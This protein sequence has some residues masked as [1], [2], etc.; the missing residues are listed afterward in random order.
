MVPVIAGQGMS[1]AGA[2]AYYFHDKRAQTTTRVAWTETM[3]LLTDCVE[4]AW[5]VMAYTAKHQECLK[6]A[7]G[8]RPGGAKL[9]KPVF[10]YSLSWHP[11]QSPTK[12]TMLEAA[13][14]S[15]AQL[16]LTEHQ[17]MIAAHTDEPQPHVHIIANTVHPLTGLVAKL[18]RTKRKLSDFA[19]NYERKEGKVYCPKREE[20]HARREAGKSTKYVD[21]VIAEVWK[22]SSDGVT[23]TVRLEAWG[24]QLARGRK[25]IVVADAHGKAVNPVRMLDGVKAADFTRRIENLDTS[26][27]PTVEEAQARLA[28]VNKN[29]QECEAKADLRRERFEER[30]AVAINALA[31]RHF[32]ETRE[33]SQRH[34]RK[35]D[36][37]RSELTAFYRLEE[38]AAG[39][40]EL[41][42]KLK[43]SGFWQKLVGLHQYR[44]RKLAVLRLNQANAK[45]RFDEAIGPMEKD[46]QQAMEGLVRTQTRE[47]EQLMRR[48]EAWRPRDHEPNR[49]PEKCHTISPPSP[50][51]S[52]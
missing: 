30:Q 49:Q 5:K 31:L 50:G 36:S 13:R 35:I 25:R 23:F 4:K 7:S 52:R 20:N 51:I 6:R 39:I 47:R 2:F 16:G 10:C 19:R 3:N 26:V 29:T 33:L 41:E 18:K 37:K 42:G 14:D 24:Y 32:D 38:K 17:V 11:E 44:E 46:K 27:L 8:Q 12:A 43:R 40:A 22:Q 48:L 45:M 34:Q 28:D 9:Q 21:P 15:L 1:F